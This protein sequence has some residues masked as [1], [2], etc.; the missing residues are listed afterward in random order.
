[1]V[2]TLLTCILLFFSQLIYAQNT[3]E[4]KLLQQMVDS[5]NYLLTNCDDGS[6]QPTVFITKNGDVAIVY[7]NNTAFRFNLFG[8]RS[9]NDEIENK[10]GIQFVPE[11]KKSI[12]TNKWI[13]FHTI[14]NQ[15]GFLKFTQTGEAFV[16]QIY[17]TLVR[18]R[19][20]IE[21]TFPLKIK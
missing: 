3:S 17:L 18:I 19:I 6:V 5:V 2:R 11:N 13:N 1:M 20:Y 15:V 21:N 10:E 8:L 12:T 7:S 16:Y 14:D 9:Q 4:E